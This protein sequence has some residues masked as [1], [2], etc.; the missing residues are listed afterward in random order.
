MIQQFPPLDMTCAGPN[1]PLAGTR[2]KDSGFSNITKETGVY[3]QQRVEREN[4]RP[5]G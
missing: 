5:G 1:G 2:D 4:L 3:L